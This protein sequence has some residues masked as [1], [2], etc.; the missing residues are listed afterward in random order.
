ML[1]KSPRSHWWTR[2]ESC[3]PAGHLRAAHLEEPRVAAWPGPTGRGPPSGR[4][5]QRGGGGLLHW[6]PLQGPRSA[7]RRLPL[8]VE[9][10]DTLHGCH[11]LCNLG[12]HFFDLGPTE[13]HPHGR[14]SAHQ[15]HRGLPFMRGLQGLPVCPEAVQVQATNVHSG[16]MHWRAHA[17]HQGLALRQPCCGHPNSAAHT[18]RHFLLCRLRNGRKC[19]FSP[20]GRLDVQPA[21]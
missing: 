19:G 18:P 15:H 12:Q 9:G 16:R 10:D 2:P 14:L 4:V 21:N 1:L 11:F 5:G 8:R 13:A 17:L 7:V 6:R 20:R 3:G